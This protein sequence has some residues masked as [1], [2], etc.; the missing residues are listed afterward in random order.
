MIKLQRDP[1]KEA[2]VKT[3]EINPIALLKGEQPRLID[4]W[5]DAP[6]IWDAVR[7][8]CDE[9]D[10]KGQFILTGSTSKKC[11]LLILAQEEY[12]N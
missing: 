6:N 5:Q 8:Y 2:F 12:Q 1:N 10:G 9:N 3:A 7:S 11:I 4:E